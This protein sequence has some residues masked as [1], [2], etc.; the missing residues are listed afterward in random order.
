MDEHGATE[1]DK[2]IER[3]AA[4]VT[5]GDRDWGFRPV[6]SFVPL[7]R[8]TFCKFEIGSASLLLLLTPV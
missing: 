6:E 2:E 4:K 7:A 3:K 8:V 1:A 5:K